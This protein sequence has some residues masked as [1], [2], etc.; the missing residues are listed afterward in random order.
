MS[1]NLLQPKSVL[2]AA[3]ALTALLLAGPRHAWAQ[4]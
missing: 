3:L 4:G 2:A 1:G